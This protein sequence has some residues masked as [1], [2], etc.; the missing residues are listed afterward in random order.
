[1][2]CARAPVRTR[3]HCSVALVAR[4]RP[5]TLTHACASLGS[6][7]CFAQ[8]AALSENKD[9]AADASDYNRLYRDNSQQSDPDTSARSQSSRH[10]QQAKAQR[11]LNRLRADGPDGPITSHSQA[12]VPPDSPIA[13]AWARHRTSNATAA[14][15]SA[16]SG[17]QTC[18]AC[19]GL[20]DSPPS[21]FCGFC[22][23]KSPETNPLKADAPLNASESTGGS[24]TVPQ[25]MRVP[26]EE[27]WAVKRELADREAEV[28]ELSRVLMNVKAARMDELLREKDG[29][30]SA[31]MGQLEKA[32]QQSAAREFKLQSNA[33]LIAE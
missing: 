13:D 22:G 14:S 27:M 4:M 1:M 9:T 11:L 12:A 17:R 26:V 16:E 2:P 23:V 25:F 21:L 3:R 28:K 29:E 6:V 5:P 18:Y 7:V 24:D 30:V 8:L 15:T 20:L 19:D 32:K 31:L 10:E 33:R